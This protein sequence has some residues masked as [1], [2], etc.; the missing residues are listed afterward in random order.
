MET[1]ILFDLDGVIYQN[2][3]AIPG[4]VETLQWVKAHHIPYLF[5][6]NT[7]S[8]PRAAVVEKLAAFGINANENLMLTPAIAASNW[9]KQQSNSPRVSLYIAEATKTDISG[10]NLVTD[11]QNVDAVVVG[12]LAQQWSFELMNTIFRQLME[13]PNSQ[14]IALGLTRYWR[15]GNTLQLD[16]GPFVKALEYATGKQAIVCGKP[17]TSF[18]QAAAQQL[19]LSPENLMMVGDDIQGDINGAQQAGL[20]AIQVRTGKFQPSDLQHNIQPDAI[21]DSI[22]DLPNWWKQ[23]ID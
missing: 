12:D 13:S 2:G 5:V 21:I 4:A 8:K 22:A 6:T 19:Q 20:R 15:T 18:F 1:G 16:V 11:E 3:K 23:H 14:L 7:S 17:S 10:C 9:L